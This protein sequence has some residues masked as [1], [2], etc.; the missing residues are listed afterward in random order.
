MEVKE[1]TFQ[2]RSVYDVVQHILQNIIPLD[3]LHVREKLNKFQETLACQ[4]PETLFGSYHW[5]RF[6]RVLN[7]TILSMDEPWQQELNKYLL[8]N[9]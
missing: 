1:T 5:N 2:P 6:I 7:Q 4:A 8:N 3:Q 9:S